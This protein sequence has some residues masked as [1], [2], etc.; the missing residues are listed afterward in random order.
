MPLDSEY[1]WMAAAAYNLS[2]NTQNQVLR[3]PEWKELQGFTTT[4]STTGFAAVVYQHKVTGET[5]IAFRGTDFGEGLGLQTAIDFFDGN[6]PLAIG[7]GGRQL[8]DAAALYFEVLGRS[9]V[10]SGKLSFTGHSLGGGL[11][12][13]MSAWFARP[14]TV[15]AAAGFQ[16]AALSPITTAGAWVAFP[17]LRSLYTTPNVFTLDTIA[18]FNAREQ[19]VRHHYIT[20]EFL[21]KFRLD[22]TTIQGSGA[23]NR[24]IDIGLTDVGMVGLHSMLLHWVATVAPEFDD[25]ARRTPSLVNLLMSSDLYSPANITLNGNADT[26]LLVRWTNDFSTRSVGD[27]PNSLLSRFLAE[28]DALPMKGIAERVVTQRAIVTAL[29]EHYYRRDPSA[30]APF[31]G[32]LGNGI[33]IDLSKA[34]AHERVKTQQAFGASFFAEI[35]LSPDIRVSTE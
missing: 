18:N 16:L 28:V 15:F 20:G 35:E 13:V 27:Q 19:L 17:Q 11:A 21:N 5:V 3:S 29:I 23:Q 32:Q 1:A 25:L 33:L 7:I 22:A 24:P 34:L 9:G 12:S 14:A 8:L 10:D 4:N 2:R 31:I 6:V 30:V 26:S